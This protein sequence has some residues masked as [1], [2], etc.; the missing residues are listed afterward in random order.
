MTQLSEKETEVL[1]FFVKK[2]HDLSQVP[3]PYRTNAVFSAD[4]RKECIASLPIK[5][6]QLNFIL[7][8]LRKKKM[9]V[10]RPNCQ[11]ALLSMLEKITPETTKLTYEF[12]YT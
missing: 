5:S 1:S 7:T 12:I 9:I 11:N 2:Y 4:S 8:S 3:E 10:T 6:S